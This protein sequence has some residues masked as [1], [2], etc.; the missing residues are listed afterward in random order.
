[1]LVPLTDP[2]NTYTKMMLDLMADQRPFPASPYPRRFTEVVEP[3]VTTRRAVG[4][5]TVAIGVLVIGV[6]LVSRVAP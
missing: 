4:L 5:A 3:S 2:Q 1:V 6:A